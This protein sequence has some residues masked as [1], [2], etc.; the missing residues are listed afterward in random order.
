M[1]TVLPLWPELTLEV[2]GGQ[3]QAEATSNL[4]SLEL[5]D[6]GDRLQTAGS[7][8]MARQEQEAKQAASGSCRPG[9]GGC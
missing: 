2:A 4:T 6:L 8:A 7:S 5:R 3:G 9:K 1:A